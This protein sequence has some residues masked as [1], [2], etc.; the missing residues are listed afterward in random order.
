[1]LAT[2]GYELVELTPVGETLRRV[3]K[4]HDPAPVSKE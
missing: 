2:K 4:D 1:M 3:S